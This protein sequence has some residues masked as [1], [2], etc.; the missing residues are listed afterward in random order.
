[1]VPSLHPEPEPE[2]P[3]PQTL[4][5]IKVKPPN[6]SGPEARVMSRPVRPR[7]WMRHATSGDSLDLGFC[8]VGV[9]GLQALSGRS[10]LRILAVSAMAMCWTQE[11]LRA[12]RRTRPNWSFG[13]GR[14]RVSKRDPSEKVQAWK[15]KSCGLKNR[16]HVCS[17]HVQLLPCDALENLN[18]SSTLHVY[19]PV[20][21]RR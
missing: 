14:L 18:R 5:S 1:M 15:P 11:G 8:C 7:P 9:L 2:K 6:S 17:C 12:M 13:L 21:D 20:P 10:M 3:K 4:S 19:E 16:D